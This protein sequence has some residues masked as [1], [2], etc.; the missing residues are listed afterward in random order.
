MKIVT[1]AEMREIDRATTEQYRVPALTLMEN[2][3][4]T[5][6]ECV[7]AMVTS[8]LVVCGKGNN[9]GDG[10]VAARHL[11]DT[12]KQVRVLLLGRP[13]EVKGDAA[14]M[15]KR[16]EQVPVCVT[17]QAGL[18][19]AIRESPRPDI[20]IDAIFG[21]GFK[22]PAQ[23]L[24]AAAINAINN[25]TVPTIAID[26]PSGIDADA[27]QATSE[28]DAFVHAHEIVTFTALKPAHVFVL[29]HV[30]TTLRQIGTPDE[31]VHSSLKLN[32][33]TRD[34][35][36][37]LFAK[38]KPESNKGT[39]G[40]VLVVGGSDGKAGA[41]AMAGMA[42][43]RTGAG[44]CTVAAPRSVQP[45]IAAFMPELMTEPL[46]E[47]LAGGM[48]VLALDRF[49]EIAKGKTVIAAGPG[50][51]MDPEAGQ[52]MRAIFDRSE[53]PLVLDADGLN[54]FV[55]HV[56]Q[57]EG[58]RRPLVMTPH[59]GELSRLTGTPIAQIQGD[60]IGAARNL[61]QPHHA[62]VV[63]KGHKTLVA[64]PDGNIWINT[65]GN[66]G[67]ATGGTGDVLTGVIAGLLAQFPRQVTKC[68]TAAVHLHG[69]AGD[70][71]VQELGEMPLVAT[72]IIRFL[73]RA[74]Q[75]L[76]SH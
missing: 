65:T 55:G 18:E 33:I 39:Y 52:F 10:F 37:E 5:V 2:A 60:R 67:M 61:A 6:A 7:P 26:L 76:Q 16:L 50:A 46:S 58:K 20:V 24:H 29:E 12:G 4:R 32:V 56:E 36:A 23:G 35:I 21:T 51:S 17:D 19:R 13:E 75:H 63:L 38:R 57:L 28:K 15:L 31:A 66:P 34:D 40:H 72:D 70:F 59:P 30:P 48:S 68:V 41:P 1:A 64:E 62:Y 71:A 47:S 73:P 25:L 8:V 49:R 45:T 14:A 3:G 22:P 11:H 43:L 27:I 74:V 69:L 54:A 9:G 53:G 42:A 44:L